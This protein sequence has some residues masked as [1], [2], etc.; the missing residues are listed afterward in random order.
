MAMDSRRLTMFI[1]G[2]IGPLASNAVLAMVPVLK[3][4]FGAGHPSP[5]ST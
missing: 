2:Y 3:A 4:E 5:S 1:G